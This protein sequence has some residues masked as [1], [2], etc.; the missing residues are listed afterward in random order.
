MCASQWTIRGTRRRRIKLLPSVGRGRVG[1][2]TLSPWARHSG[3]IETNT[4]H[5]MKAPFGLRFFW[6]S[7]RPVTSPHP[8]PTPRSTP[9]RRPRFGPRAFDPFLCSALGRPSS[10]SPFAPPYPAHTHSR[11]C[12]IKRARKAILR[13]RQGRMDLSGRRIIRAAV[14]RAGRRSARRHQGEPR[15]AASTAS[16]ASA[17]LCPHCHMRPGPTERNGLTP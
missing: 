17:V 5:A 2:A 7:S 10:P 8:H 11:A 12:D 6:Q 15:C 16:T 14:P 1:R 4:F 9:C 3:A 13:P